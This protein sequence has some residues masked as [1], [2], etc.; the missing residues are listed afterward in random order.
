ML[1]DFDLDDVWVEKFRPGTLDEMILD[2]ET[3]EFF[4][5]KL[6]DGKIPHILFVSA[7]GSGKTSLAKIIVKEL[8]YPID[9]LMLRMNEALTL[10]GKKLLTLHRLSHLMGD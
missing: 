4:K 10:S 9:I 8:G 3:L 1:N 2:S 7:P 6:K 5:E